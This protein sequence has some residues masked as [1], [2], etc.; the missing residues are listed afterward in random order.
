MSS[1]IHKIMTFKSGQFVFTASFSNESLLPLIVKSNILL[2]SIKNLPIL[3]H[4]A[5]RMQEELVKKSIFSTAAIEGNPL[6]ESTVIELLNEKKNIHYSDVSKIEIQN[7][8]NAYNYLYEIESPDGF[9]II[10]E[11]L[12]QNIHQIISKDIDY[13][14]NTPGMYRNHVVKV[15]DGEHGGIY[16]PPK[17]RE[18]VANL[19]KEFSQWINCKQ[20]RSVHPII[21]A[22][23]AHYHLGLIHPFGDGNG[24]TARLIEAIIL[25]TSGIRFLPVTLSNYYYRNIDEYYL[26]FS[27]TRKSKEYDVTYF[28]EF[29]LTGAIESL[30]EI[31]ESIIDHI[32]ILTLKDYYQQLKSEKKISPRQHDLLSILLQDVTH[33]FTLSDI[34]NHPALN[35]L[36]RN[37]SPSTIRR[38][39]KKLLHLNLLRVVQEQAFTIN[40]SALG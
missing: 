9:L 30:E 29:V 25:Q 23:L 6:P 26:A 13:N 11:E 28:L 40:L 16:T 34:L 15:G 19:S 5:N 27:K 21:R 32:R 8:R 36:Y 38:D 1:P 37:V 10:E 31:S 4:N 7:L 3:P 22:A 14:G 18:D 2:K 24:R 17:I 35:I 39:I 20:V 12:I 33:Q